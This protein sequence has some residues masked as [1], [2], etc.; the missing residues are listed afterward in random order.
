MSA[1]YF[2]IALFAAFCYALDATLMAKVYRSFDRLSAVAHRGFAL[3]ISMAPLL[4][5]VSKA[6]FV[7]GAPYLHYMLLACLITAVGNVLVAHAVNFVPVGLASTLG[8]SV[9]TL[10]AAVFGSFV[11]EQRLSAHAMA[12]GALLLAALVVLG[13]SGPADGQQH[14]NYRKG[15]PLALLFGL[16]VGIGFSLVAWF[17]NVSHPFWAGYLWEAGIGVSA[18]VFAC[19]RKLCGG[20]GFQWLRA[21]G[22]GEVFLRCA[23]T[24]GGTGGYA[25]AVT[26]G[27]L[28]LVAATTSVDVVIVSLLAIPF[29]GEILSRR[30]WTLIVIIFMLV[31]GLKLAG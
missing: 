1:M 13:T 17:A 10:T 2:F 4:L 21:R 18:F 16:L 27:P 8:M 31:S 12:L 5:C 28:A 29:Y 19:G 11:L 6:Q 24:V 7:A 22:F 20:A 14:W 23:P 3:T 26:L 25:L 9:S 30:Q 15:V